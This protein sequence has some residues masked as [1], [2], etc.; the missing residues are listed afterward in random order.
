MAS[1]SPAVLL[2]LLVLEEE[3]EMLARPFSFNFMKGLQGTGSKVS[4]SHM[5]Q[6]PLGPWALL[7]QWRSELAHSGS[8]ACWA[9]CSR[10]KRCHSQ[11][12]WRH[13]EHIP[14]LKMTKTIL[15]LPLTLLLLFV[16][17]DFRRAGIG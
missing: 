1:P 15:S 6:D 4:L 16:G 3:R 11:L 7:R 8:P 17:A 5:I 10:G 2:K 13:K 14:G 9:L 12:A